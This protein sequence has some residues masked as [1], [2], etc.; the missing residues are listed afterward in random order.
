[1]FKA[2][3]GKGRQSKRSHAPV[4]S[5]SNDAGPGPAKEDDIGKRDWTELLGSTDLNPPQS[6]TRSSSSVGS[7]DFG[8]IQNVSRGG[9][10]RGLH[11]GK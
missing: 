4:G 9:L 3:N 11:T 8:G 6:A 1:M 2:G 10:Q 7:T 5:R